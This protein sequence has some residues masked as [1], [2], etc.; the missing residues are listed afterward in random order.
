M[1]RNPENLQKWREGYREKQR[2]YCEAWR[3]ANKAK[4]ATYM[5]EHRKK[6]PSFKLAGNLRCRLNA[7]LGG[8]TRGVSA[9][10]DLGCSIHDLKQYLESL[11]QTGMNWDNYGPNGWHVDHKTPLANFDLTNREQLLKACHY[12]NLQPMWAQENK[13]KGAR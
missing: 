10:R 13:I 9:V 5:R 12:T 6:N 4:R 11:F 1:A 2:A 3:Q 7:A 8:R